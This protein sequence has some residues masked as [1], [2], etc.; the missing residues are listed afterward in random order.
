MRKFITGLLVV[1]SLGA[2]SLE[3]AVDSSEESSQ[4]EETSE[5]TLAAPEQP[6]GDANLSGCDLYKGVVPV[7]C[8]PFYLEKGRPLPREPRDSKIQVRV[9]HANQT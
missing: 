5:P 7:E 8:N 1:L 9:V 3:S 6:P 2:C 4:E